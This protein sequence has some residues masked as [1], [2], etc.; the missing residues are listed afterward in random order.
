[1][2]C[3]NRLVQRINPRVGPPVRP[4][5][6]EPAAGVKA[7]MEES[8][9]PGGDAMD[10]K[11]K[12]GPAAKPAKSSAETRVFRFKG[13]KK[14]SFGEA[15]ALALVL[16][17]ALTGKSETIYVP[18]ADPAKYGP[19]AEVAD[20]MKEIK[21]GDLVEVRTDRQKG[22]TIAT[23]LAKAEFVAGEDR[24]KGYVFVGWDRKK[25]AKGE[26]EMALRL[27]KF[28]KEA[29]VMVPLTLDRDTGD[30]NPSRDVDYVLGRVQPGEA[31]EADIK[32]GKPPVL[33]KIYEYY[34]PERGKFIGLGEM[35]FNGYTALAVEMMRQRR[36]EAAHPPARHRAVQE[37]QADHDARP[38]PGCDDP[39]DQARL[40][41]RGLHAHAQ[42]LRPPRDQRRQPTGKEVRQVRICQIG[43]GSGKVCVSEICPSLR[44]AHFAAGLARRDC[45]C[46]DGLIDRGRAP[47]AERLSGTCPVPLPAFG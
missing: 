3:A 42:R 16:E 38:R 19:V 33:D 34:R 7:K 46:S 18:N 24:P 8:M 2:N 30:W 15:P 9:S 23:S 37:R 40:G 25:N 47:Q 28:G 13:E 21:P 43:E 20:A 27:K 35:D 44:P 4:A 1:M 6:A 26:T 17:D 41:D 10:A 22:K 36:H 29:I 31:V 14:A 45:T 5:S 32:P 12:S 11:G 39:P